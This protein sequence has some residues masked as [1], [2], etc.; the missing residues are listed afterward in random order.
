MKCHPGSRTWLLCGAL[1]FLVRAW[2][3]AGNAAEGEV[4][5]EASPSTIKLATTIEKGRVAVIARNKTSVP[6]QVIKLDHIESD[7]L[8]VTVSRNDREVSVM[9]PGGALRWAVEISQADAARDAG[10]VQ[11]FL[12]YTAAEARPEAVAANSAHVAIAVQLAQPAALE[13]VL[14]ARTESSLKTLSD[15]NSGIVFVVVRNK[16]IFP[17]SVRS[18]DVA[19]SADLEATWK[20][21][22]VNTPIPPQTERAFSARVERK[23]AILPG[24]CLLLF[25]IN[26]DWVEEGA[27]RSGSTIAKFEFE[28]DV[29]GDSAMLTAIGV[30]SFLLLPGFLMLL[31]FGMLW[32]AAVK[33]KPIALDFKQ[34][35]FWAGAILLSLSTALVYPLVTGRN[36]LQGYSFKDV[37]YVWFGSAGVGAIAWAIAIFVRSRRA[38][39]AAEEARR[40]TFSKDDTPVEAL[41][42]LAR[43][44]LGFELEPVNIQLQG[45][46]VR[47]FLLEQGQGDQAHWVAPSIG[48]TLPANSSVS[49]EEVSACLTK[50]NAPGELADFIEKKGV[51]ATWKVPQEAHGLNGLTQVSAYTPSGARRTSLAE[52]T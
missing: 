5:L 23:G 37:C 31:I 18:I 48:L 4:T 42:K 30:P 13:K 11:F 39:R 52:I 51:T 46:A 43:K 6:V 35:Q 9:P 38:R 29:I 22:F 40:R 25:T 33:I 20:E 14:E 19:P 36:Y 28:A 12:D 3:C 10:E 32:N 17:V 27:Q 49:T 47:A 8:T 41:R 16:S 21:S 34:P 24:K 15:P 1:F 2:P 45:Q 44:G 50:V 26:A 7:G